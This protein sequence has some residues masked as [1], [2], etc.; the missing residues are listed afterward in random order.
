MAGPNIPNIEA[1][2]AMGI[3]PKTRAPI[4][5]APKKELKTGV[6][7]ALRIMDEQNAV[8]RY[9]WYNLPTGLTSDLI[10]RILYYRYQGAFFYIKD[11]DKFFFLPFTPT[12]NKSN[13]L[14]A[15]GRV[16]HVT[17]LPFMG[18]AEVKK[19]SGLLAYL[20]QKSFKTV[21]TPIGLEDLSIDAIY[22]SAVILKDYTEQLSQT[23]IARQIIND[24]IIQFESECMP[25]LRTSLIANS[26]IKGFKVSNPDDVDNVIAASRQIE[27][28]AID[29]SIYVPIIG[30]VDFQD[31]A[32]S[33]GSSRAEEFLMAMQS[34]DNFRLSTFGLDSGGVFEKKAH[35]LEAEQAMN[36]SNVGLI[37]Q[38]GLTRRQEFCNIVNSIW[39]LSIW[40]EP[41]ETVLGVDQNLDGSIYD[42]SYPEQQ[43]ANVAGGET[44]N[45]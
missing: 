33:G 4:K 23:G 22:E 9:K 8:R 14:D 21:Y 27:N 15:Y 30:T 11:V 37:Y 17:P 43:T 40:C 26:G 36:K 16:T 38:D 42:V 1:L 3:D 6:M 7:Q 44:E 28:A 10:E 31:L 34:I 2:I 39:G 13:F 35:V 25:F 32:N 20:G 45:E 12:S 19:S 24:P 18:T 29:G 5:I 41:S